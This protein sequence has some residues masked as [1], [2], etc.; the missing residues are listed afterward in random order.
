M[1]EVQKCGNK[2]LYYPIYMVGK[3]N[4]INDSIYLSKSA[5]KI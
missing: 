3:N 4:E 5:N 1:F 2:S